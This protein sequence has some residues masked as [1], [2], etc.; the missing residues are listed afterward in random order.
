MAIERHFTQG[1]GKKDERG[2]PV[3]ARLEKAE[4]PVKPLK[5]ATRWLVTEE[6]GA[7]LIDPA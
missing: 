6:R 4:S 3:Y 5:E 7:K 1:E 2:S